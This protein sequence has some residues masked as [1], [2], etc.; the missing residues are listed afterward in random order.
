MEAAKTPSAHTKRGI[1][2]N[3]Y[4][5][6]IV[7]MWFLPVALFIVLP[8]TMLCCWLVWRAVAPRKARL[9]FAVREIKAIKPEMLAKAGV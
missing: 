3:G 2:M 7:W 8:L 9:A 4:A 1:K 6:V 5:E